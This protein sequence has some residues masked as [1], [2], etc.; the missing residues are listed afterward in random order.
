MSPSV[1]GLIQDRR[2]QTT[3]YRIQDTG[4]CCDVV[5]NR[6]S[7]AGSPLFSLKPGVI[8]SRM[9]YAFLSESPLAKLFRHE[10]L[11]ARSGRFCVVSLSSHGTG[12]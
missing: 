4:S 7:V 9:G 12:S 6:Y 10:L 3:G 5:Q 11:A 2:L 8:A 1:G